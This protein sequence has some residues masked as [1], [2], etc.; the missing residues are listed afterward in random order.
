MH[1]AFIC[2]H[3]SIAGPIVSMGLRVSE[4]QGHYFEDVT[5]HRSR[6]GWNYGDAQ[7]VEMQ[8]CRDHLH[9]MPV[10]H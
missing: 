4:L 8:R 7:Q 1:D 5:V 10:W 9:C 2:E 6:S 3:V